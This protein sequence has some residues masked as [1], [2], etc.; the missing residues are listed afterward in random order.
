MYQ[1]VQLVRID[2]RT[3]DVVILAGEEIEI[4]VSPNGKWRFER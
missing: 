2:E 4:I 1:T 3:R